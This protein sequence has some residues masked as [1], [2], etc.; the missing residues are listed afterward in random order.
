MLTP[1]TQEEVAKLSETARKELE[2]K[3]KLADE[4]ADEKK[5]LAEENERLRAELKKEQPAPPSPVKQPLSEADAEAVS[6]I[7]AQAAKEDKE[8]Y[9]TFEVLDKHQLM[10]LPE[11]AL[12]PK[13][14]DLKRDHPKMLVPFT[15][16]FAEACAGI[17]VKKVLTI[18]HRW[19]DPKLADVDG[20]QLTAIRKHLKEKG[21]DIE[22]I[23]MDFSCMPQG[24]EKTAAQIADFR[25]MISQVNL[26]YLGT[27]V[28]ILLDLSYLS[29]FWTQFEAWLS[30]QQA[31]TGKLCR[32]SGEERRE[33]I[34][35]IYN[36][37]A[38]AKKLLEEQ[39]SDVTPEQ[40]MVV[41]ATPDVTVTNQSD[42][43]TQ[44]ARLKIFAEN[45]KKVNMGGFKLVMTIERAVGKKPEGRTWKEEWV[46]AWMER[47]KLEGDELA[48]LEFETGGVASIEKKIENLAADI[49][50]KVDNGWPQE[51]AEAYTVITA[52]LRAPLAAAVR[53]RSDRYAASTHLVCDVL[54]ERAKQMTEAAPL[55]YMNLTGEFGLA[56][57]DPA[58]EALTQPGA[59]AGL[60]FVTNG[61]VQWRK[62]TTAT[63]PTTRATAST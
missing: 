39:W 47:C 61:L 22:Y 50:W 14:Q 41:L 35:T 28:L 18:S 55:V 11:G 33:T 29:R 36:G 8:A 57:D 13:Y 2:E 32:A 43:T 62:Q 59:S 24:E 6:K 1:R 38:T 30:M 5:K 26:L 51:Q 46:D 7:K 25:R 4:L 15:I 54:A 53:E 27:S 31:T 19:M 16:S 63:F 10:D 56:T 9:C 44:I 52:N 21:E 58:W 20:T 34:V 48:S 42:K 45:V 3:K 23:W 49:K 12:M 40:A 17:H 37:T 60:G